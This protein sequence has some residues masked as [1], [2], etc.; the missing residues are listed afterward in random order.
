MVLWLLMRLMLSSRMLAL[1]AA[2]MM[3]EAATLLPPSTKMGC[4][5]LTKG[6]GVLFV[7]PPVLVLAVLVLTEAMLA[8]RT[9]ARLAPW[10]MCTTKGAEEVL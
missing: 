3:T 4:I 7:L 10:A 1:V 6:R 5:S 2:A 9:S 8:Q